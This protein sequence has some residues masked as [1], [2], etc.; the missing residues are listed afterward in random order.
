MM[1][2][3]TISLILLALL[4]GACHRRPEV[5]PSMLGKL[6]AV[7]AA[8]EMFKLDHDRFP[9][10]LGELLPATNGFGGGALSGYIRPEGLIDSWG[11]RLDYTTQGTGYEL[12]CAGRDRAFQTADDIVKTKE[13]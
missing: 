13:K 3:G 10:T 5:R 12:R 1:R 6:N 8:L 2:M 11:L 7:A 9:A 4:T